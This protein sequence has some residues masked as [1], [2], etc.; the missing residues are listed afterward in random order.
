MKRSCLLLPLIVVACNSGPTVSAT[1]ASGEEVAAKVKAS[2]V[3]NVFVSP[4]HWQMT[5]TIGEL[6]IPGMTPAMAEKMKAHMGK[7][8]VFESCVTPEEAAKPKEDFFAKGTGN[9]RYQHFAMGA[10]KIDAAMQCREDGMSRTMTMTGTY[11]PDS[12][13]MN[14]SSAGEGQAGNPMGGMTM[15]M[16][17]AAKRTG[18]CTGKE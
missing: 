5:M 2:G 8:R 6:S 7:P 14:M 15:K 3:Q 9:C 4:G 16:N 18:P 11:G 10:G 12:Y 13:Q 17:M 1:N